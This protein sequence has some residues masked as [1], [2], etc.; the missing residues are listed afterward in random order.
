MSELFYDTKTI[1]YPVIDSD[2]HVQEPPDLW[3][4]RAP[5]KL[6]A[7]APK[8]EQTPNGDV[9][10]FDDGRAMQPVGLT[11]CAG[12]SYLQYTPLGRS[13]A[14]IRPGCYEVAARLEDMQIDGI[15][16]QVLY[17]SVTLGGAK[18]Y[19]NDP[20]LQ[21]FCVRAYNEWIG[22]L[23]EQAPTQLFANAIIP[24][25]GLDDA[26]DE[27]EWAIKHGHRGAVIS[28]M[29]NG[30][31][32]FSPA[33]EAFFGLAQEAR[34]PVAVHIGSFIRDGQI[35]QRKISFTELAFLGKAGGAKSGAH[36]LPVTSDLIFSG[37]FERFP[38]LDLVLV[39][40]NIG[41]IPTLL[42]QTDDMFLRYRWFTQATSKMKQMPSDI[43][44]RNFWA[45]FMVD[46]VGMEL[47]H[48][49]NIDHLMWSTD[50]PHTGSDWP[51]SRVTIE[52]VFRGVPKAEVKKMLH[53]N[54]KR[55]YR[56]GS[57]PDS[58]PGR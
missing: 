37:I 7:R 54:A 32:D 50:Y 36:T 18:T 31:F 13:Y 17:P 42:E 10:S 33:D 52:R 4:K 8:V 1:D 34:M 53:D 6:K 28:R 26:V 23:C 3:Q 35:D 22:E 21:R 40:S 9:W 20:E 51:N 12:L 44:Q 24:T 56:L 47:R 27:L 19:G 45:T 41:W 5:A 57:V 2:A 38:K 39:E 14:G 29:P 58:L 43:F 46:T 48:R 11:T 55:L 49:M 16:A 15:Y 30:S 25:T